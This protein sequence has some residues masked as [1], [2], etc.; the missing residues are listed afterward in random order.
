[1]MLLR[2]RDEDGNHKVIGLETIILLSPLQIM[3]N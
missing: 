3:P 1:M 2:I